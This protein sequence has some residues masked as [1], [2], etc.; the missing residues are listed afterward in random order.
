MRRSDNSLTHLNW[1]PVPTPPALP[2][3]SLL[4]LASPQLTRGVASRQLGGLKTRDG[5]LAGL[6][7]FSPRFA[8]E[9]VPVWFPPDIPQQRLLYR[10]AVV[11]PRADVVI[12]ILPEGRRRIIAEPAC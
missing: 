8:P 3:A 12:E 9:I 7:V 1:S 4:G 2:I 6:G 5:R 11:S 10:V